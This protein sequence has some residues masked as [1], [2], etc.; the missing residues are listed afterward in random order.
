V[1]GSRDG[2]FRRPATL[3]GYY[4]PAPANAARR[5]AQE[6]AMIELRNTILEDISTME[7]IQRS[8]DAG[9]IR[10]IHFHDHEVALR[11]QNHVV[12]AILEGR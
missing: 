3:K 11:H 7:G 9:V 4:Y 1:A 8:F 10:E 5:F 2:L 6:Y 12:T